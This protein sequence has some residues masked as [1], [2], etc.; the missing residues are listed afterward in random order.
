MFHRIGIF[1]LNFQ[2]ICVNFAMC[3]FDKINCGLLH[4]KNY[5]KKDSV[6]EFWYIVHFFIIVIC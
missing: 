1:Y 2:A 6:M 3:A 4:K 5:F